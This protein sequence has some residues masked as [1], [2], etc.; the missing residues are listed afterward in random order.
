MPVF[1]STSERRRLRCSTGWASESVSEDMGGTPE[2]SVAQFGK[3]LVLNTP[4]SQKAL[5]LQR[6]ALQL[7][8]HAR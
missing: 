6:R 3:C 5:Q 8:S 2:R 4:P 1:R 7:Q